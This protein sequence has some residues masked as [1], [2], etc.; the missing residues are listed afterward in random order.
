VLKGKELYVHGA[1]FDLPFLYHRDG[2]KPPGNV[3]DTLHLS[4]VARA[5]E[6]QEK[7]D[8]GWER[9]RHSLKDALERELGVTLGDKKKFQRGKAWSGDLTDEHLEYA[10]GDVV[11]LKALAD[12]LL[13]LIEERDL[14]E[15]WKLEQRAKPL[16]LD[17]CIRGI[18]LDNGRWDRLIGELE[19]RVLSLK[20]KVDELAPS[21]LEVG[22]WNWNSPKQAKEAFSLAGLKVPDLKRETLLKHDHPLIHA[23]AGYRDTQ[24]LLS[25][26]RTWATGR[27]QDGRVYPQ[28][29]PAGAATGRASCTSPNVQSLSRA[30]GFRGCICPGEGRVL[31]K[32]DLSQIELRVLAAITKDENMLKVFGEGGD[33]HLAT[34]EAVAGR[35]IEKGSPERQRAK[36]VNFGLSFGMGAKRFQSMALKDYGVKMTLE[37]A[38]KAKRRLLGAYPKIGDWHTREGQQCER[39]NFVTETLMGRRR[40]VEPD[41]WGKPSFTERLNAPVQG[42]AAD[43]LKLALARLWEKREEHPVAVPILSVHDEIVLECAEDAEVAGHWLSS[44]LRGAVEDVLGHPELAGHDVVETSVVGSWGEA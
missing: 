43:I 10:A 23:V 4:Q 39:G 29:K 15:V 27:Y 14:N 2:F 24:S 17:M 21:H 19:D 20:E 11:H 26:V 1:E 32:A 25:R 41:R 13:A 30:G 40:V 31:I 34:A 42:T 6:W 16:F 28:W 8:G 38:R 33:I 22:T 5:G 35:K 44:T 12:R 3:I 36:A 9:K 18:P 37:E 7:A